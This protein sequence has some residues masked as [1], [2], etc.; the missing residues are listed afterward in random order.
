[1]GVLSV[2]LEGVVY[3]FDGEGD[4]VVVGKLGGWRGGNAV[5]VSE[6]RLRG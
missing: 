6:V 2:V 1:M 3:G 5:N 4:G